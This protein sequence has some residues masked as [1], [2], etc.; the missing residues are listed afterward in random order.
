MII[1][2]EYVAKN[3]SLPGVPSATENLLW[4]NKN[5]SRSTAS[6]SVNNGND[7]VTCRKIL[8]EKYAI[9]W[10]FAIHCQD[11]DAYTAVVFKT[12]TDLAMDSLDVVISVGH[13]EKVNTFL[14]KY[15]R[16]NYCFK[17]TAFALRRQGLEKHSET[18]PVFCR[19]LHGRRSVSQVAHGI[20]QHAIA[21]ESE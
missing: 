15:L 19:L 9:R 5:P 20:S 17:G 13:I 16:I 11:P 3:I 7:Y 6:G 18:V 12:V 8:L 14:G 2:R 4:P 21:P 1:L 10:L